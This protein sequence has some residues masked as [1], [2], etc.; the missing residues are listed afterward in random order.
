M[1]TLGARG[2]LGGRGLAVWEYR[3]SEANVEL[4]AQ[5]WTVAQ[6]GGSLSHYIAPFNGHVLG[7]VAGPEDGFDARLFVTVGGATV[8]TAWFDISRSGSTIAYGGL[9]KQPPFFEAGDW[10]GV[11]MGTVAVAAD[12]HLQMYVSLDIV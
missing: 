11:L 12:I 10:V 8:T 9:F 7:I 1:V 3:L 2:L 4:A 5:M 6:S